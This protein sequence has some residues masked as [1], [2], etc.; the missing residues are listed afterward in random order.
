MAAFAILTA[1]VAPRPQPAA[2]STSTSPCRT[3]SSRSSPPPLAA[4]FAVGTDLA[5]R[6]YVLNGGAPYYDVYQTSDGRWF[7]LGAVEPKFFA[8]LCTVIGRQDLI[9]HHTSPDP[10]K[11]RQIHDAL[12]AEFKT[13]TA[14]EW[15]HLLNQVDVCAAPVLTPAQAAADPHNRAR[16]MI[17]E[18]EGPPGF[19]NGS[20]A[21]TQ[22]GIAPKLGHTPG[23]IRTPAPA[24]GQ[25]T[26][27]VLPRSR[28]QR[29]HHRPLPRIWRHRLTLAPLRPRPS[30]LQR[31]SH[32]CDGIDAAITECGCSGGATP[33]CSGS[34]PCARNHSDPATSVDAPSTNDVLRPQRSA[35]APVGTSSVV[36]PIRNTA[37]AAPTCVSENPRSISR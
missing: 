22:I 30:A 6:S 35:T 36:R 31:G 19:M 3:A 2:A 15:F 20:R 32:G 24:P 18:V 5:P 9:E 33:A 23:R 10:D 12:S 8:N 26:D 13:K 29:R 34:R 16:G 11:R 1:V 4:H 27:E 37:S 21:M 17:L 7:S 25:H 28:P 14:H